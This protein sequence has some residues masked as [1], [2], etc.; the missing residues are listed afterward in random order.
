MANTYYNVEFGLKIAKV[1]NDKRK[2]IARHH[3]QMVKLSNFADAYVHQLSGGMKQR[4]SIARALALNPKALLMDEPFAALDVNTRNM[5]QHELLRIHKAT[6]KT[7]LFVTHNINEA[8]TL[9]DRVIVLSPKHARQINHPMVDAITKEIM[10]EA[11]EEEKGEGFEVKGDES[12][13]EV[14]GEGM[15]ENLTVAT[16]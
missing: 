8:V 5:L 6:N 12:V 1:S 14:E 3:I 10:L 16:V 4:V 13:T 15:G 9:A 7:I 2:E 11:K